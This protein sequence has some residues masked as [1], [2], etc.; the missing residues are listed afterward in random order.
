MPAPKCEVHVRHCCCCGLTPGAFLIGLYTLIL[1]ALLAIL[2]AWALQ[3][4]ATN[5]DVPIY[6]N[7]QLEAQDKINQHIKVPFGNGSFVEVLDSSNYHCSLGMYT[8]EMKYA[9]GGRTLALLIALCV[10]IPM[11]V[12]S[13][14]VLIGICLHFSWLLL[15]WLIIM[16]LDI[17]RGLV[18]TILILILNHGQLARIATGIFFL[19]LQFLH[20]SLWILVLAKFLRMRQHHV[21]VHHQYDSRHPY[22]PGHQPYGGAYYGPEGGSYTYSPNSGRR[23][24]VQTEAED[25]A[26]RQGRSPHRRYYDDGGSR[27]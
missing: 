4:T 27:Y 15:P 2:A 9:A 18:S 23:I 13:L 6:Q 12:A 21:V 1:Y 19:G 8:E 26:A 5:G 22:P 14:L 7:C 16:P 24:P 20:I 3:E 10:Y 25:Y 17:I 11:I